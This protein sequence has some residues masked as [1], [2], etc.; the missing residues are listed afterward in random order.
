[1]GNQRKLTVKIS[2]R[3]F[4]NLCSILLVGCDNIGVINFFRE[5]NAGIT[6]KCMGN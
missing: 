6:D 2:E 5:L 1:M 3:R 4:I